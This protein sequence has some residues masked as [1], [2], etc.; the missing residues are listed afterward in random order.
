[1]VILLAVA[2]SSS[3]LVCRQAV[4]CVDLA[5]QDFTLGARCEGALFSQ[6]N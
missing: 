4:R 6:R 5:M 3:V 2:Y 1:M